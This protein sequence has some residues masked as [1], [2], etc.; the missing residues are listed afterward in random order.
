MYCRIEAYDTPAGLHVHAIILD[1]QR[2]RDGL[3]PVLDRSADESFW[4]RSSTPADQLQQVA[5]LVN[6][7]AY[8]TVQISNP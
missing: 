6:D 1:D 5:S 7:L 3:V 4:S 8:K 2:E